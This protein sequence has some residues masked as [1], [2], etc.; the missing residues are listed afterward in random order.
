VACGVDDRPIE[1]E[2][3]PDTAN[4]QATAT[5]A[6]R[7]EKAC[8]CF[9][10]TT[11]S[12]CVEASACLPSTRCGPHTCTVGDGCAPHCGFALAGCIA[13]CVEEYRATPEEEGCIDR[14]GDWLKLAATHGVTA[15]DPRWSEGRCYALHECGDFW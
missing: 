15:D 2:P 9:E 4:T 8:R 13:E 11:Q 10:G 5:P 1:G 6:S 3:T 12:G 14:D 7:C